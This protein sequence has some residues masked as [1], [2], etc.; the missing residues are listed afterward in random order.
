M[1]DVAASRDRRANTHARV[2]TEFRY[3]VTRYI[4]ASRKDSKLK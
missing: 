2:Y 3:L 4:H 1:Q